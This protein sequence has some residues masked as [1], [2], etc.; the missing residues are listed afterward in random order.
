MF[1]NKPSP[2]ECWDKPTR[3]FR[4]IQTPIL[5]QEVQIDIEKYGLKVAFA[6]IKDEELDGQDFFFEERRKMLTKNANGEIYAK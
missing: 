3:N 1:R 2:I 5:L 4:Q 6:Q